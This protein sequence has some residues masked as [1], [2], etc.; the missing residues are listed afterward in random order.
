MSIEL[1]HDQR[2]LVEVAIASVQQLLDEVRPVSATAMIGDGDLAPS[3]QGIDGD[4]QS[5]RAVA[6]VFAIAPLDLTWSGWQRLADFAD[7]LL[8]GFV[9]AHYG[10]GDRSAG[11]RRPARLPCGRRTQRWPSAG[12]T[13]SS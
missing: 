10:A 9:Q 7:Q 3:C 13:A 4:K 6:D 12:C 11:D 2:H 5:G 8:G 1:I